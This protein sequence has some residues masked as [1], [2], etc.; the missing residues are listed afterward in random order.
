[1]K[2]KSLFF[3]LV[4]FFVT[5]FISCSDS[6]SADEDNFVINGKLYNAKEDTVYLEELTINERVVL[7][8][9]KVD[10]KGEFI[11]KY[12]PLQIGFYILKIDENNFVTLL[13]DK[14]ETINVSADARELANSYKLEGSEG[15]ELIRA[16][17]AKLR[18]N[19]KRVDS[20]QSVFEK[21]RYLDNF[22]QI[23]DSLDLIYFEILND[24][25]KYVKSFIDSNLTSLAS[26][27][28]LYQTFGQEPVLS[29][30]EDFA[31]FEKLSTSLIKQYPN[32]PHSQDLYKRVQEIKKNI[33]DKLKA[34]ELLKIGNVAPEITLNNTDGQVVTLSSLK[35]KTVLI[36]FWASWCGPCR[37]ANP[38]IRK[39]YQKFKN[40]GFEIYGV[41]FD[42]DK[43][44]WLNAIKM[45]KLDWINVSDLL[46]WQSPLAKL[47]NVEAIPY[48]YLIDKEGKIINKDVN[49]IELESYLKVNLK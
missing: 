32:N 20:L 25:K 48:N 27:I 5:V 15:S 21:S 49:I 11:F 39:V 46:Y 9:V 29:E 8:S 6:K 42:R 36:D 3:C 7:D 22:M 14:G 41:S 2:I 47:Y 16:I 1:M 18:N 33:K 37:K 30:K 13:I 10:K 24:Q 4:F 35:G 19:Y 40:K 38:E 44:A 34:E 12:K 26:L 23:K 43:Q 45:D 28:A 31:F 17:N